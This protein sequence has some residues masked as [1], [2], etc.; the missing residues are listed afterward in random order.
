MEFTLEQTKPKSD[1]IWDNYVPIIQQGNTYG[2]YLTDAIEAPG[3]YNQLIYL[4][5]NLDHYNTVNIF[6]NNGGGAVDSAFMIREAILRSKAWTTAH[7]SG[8]VASAAT[9]IALSCDDFIVTPFLSFMA[10][11]Y[12]HGVQGTGK[13]MLTLMS[14]LATT[15]GEKR[16]KFYDQVYVT[17]SPESV[18]KGLYT[19]FKPGDTDQKLAG[20]LGGFKSNL[21]FLLDDKRAKESRKNKR[22]DDEDIELASDKAWQENFTVVEIDEIQGTS[23]HYSILLVDEYQKLNTDSLKLILSRIA[24]GSKVVLMG[25]TQGQVYGMNRADEGF[26]TLYKHFGTA[27]KFSYIK[28]SNIYR[29]ELAK[30]IEQIFHD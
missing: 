15:Q 28:L 14:A 12:F 4:L 22:V 11:N 27:E 26:K 6:I 1:S 13:T 20:H 30:F 16:Y 8:T 18:N 24:E 19:G 7:L 9:V 21:K 17:A 2:V 23:L 25:D 29:S 5:G 10:H 3:E